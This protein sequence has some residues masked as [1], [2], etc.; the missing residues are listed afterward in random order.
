MR[1][2]FQAIYEARPE[3]VERLARALRVPLPPR[4]EEPALLRW[5]RDAANTLARAIEAER[6]FLTRA[7]APW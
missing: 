2:D 1:L 4:P 7:R 6:A 3:N 5:R